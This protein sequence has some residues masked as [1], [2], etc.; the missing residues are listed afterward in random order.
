MRIGVPSKTVVRRSGGVADLRSVPSRHL[1]RRPPDDGGLEGISCDV[2][3]DILTVVYLYELG[4]LSSRN[5][6]SDLLR[7]VVVIGLVPLVASTRLSDG[8]TVFSCPEA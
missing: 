5:V 2:D 4:I 6:R 7:S 8:K 1:R 3:A